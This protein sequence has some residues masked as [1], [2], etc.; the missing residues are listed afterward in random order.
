MMGAT[1]S[2]EESKTE[3]L[4][5]EVESVCVSPPLD[6]RPHLTSKYRGTDPASSC[7]LPLP[8]VTSQREGR[9]YIAWKRVEG[10]T[11]RGVFVR[12]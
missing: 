12:E 10:R 8:F 11:G 4:S 6:H 9:E 7:K 1:L 3:G 5:Q 2:C